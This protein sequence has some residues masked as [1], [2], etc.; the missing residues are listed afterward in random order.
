LKPLHHPLY[1]PFDNAI[2]NRERGWLVEVKA[3]NMSSMICDLMGPDTGGWE[4]WEAE[5]WVVRNWN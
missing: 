3:G 5:A 4:L 2:G 1:H